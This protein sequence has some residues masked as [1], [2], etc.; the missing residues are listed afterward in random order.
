MPCEYDWAV[1]A[2][3][4]KT[5]KGENERWGG[6]QQDGSCRVAPGRALLSGPAA[7]GLI[8]VLLP[9]WFLQRFGVELAVWGWC[10]PDDVSF[11]PSACAKYGVFWWVEPKNSS[12]V[13]FVMDLDEGGQ[14]VLVLQKKK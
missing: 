9:L 6:W 5:M 2:V 1:I 3:N 7:L 13:G 12:Q 14:Y 8:R 4:G 10:L 11:T